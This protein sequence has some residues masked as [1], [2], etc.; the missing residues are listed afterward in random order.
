MRPATLSGHAAGWSDL[1]EAGVGWWHSPA[2]TQ[3]RQVDQL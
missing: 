1:L 3:Q 2:H